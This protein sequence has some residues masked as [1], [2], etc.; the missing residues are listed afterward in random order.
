MLLSVFYNGQ[1]RSMPPK[2]LTDN[3]G[4]ILIRPLAYCQ[5]KD[6]IKYAQEQCFPLIPCN[7]FGS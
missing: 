5:E 1:I 7:L 3:K 2:L 6:I 4:H